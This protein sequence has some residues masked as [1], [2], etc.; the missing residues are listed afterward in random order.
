MLPLTLNMR[1]LNG[2]EK[3]YYLDTGL[4]TNASRPSE[5][6]AGDIMLYGTN[7]LLLFS[8]SFSP[9]YSY[10]PIGHIDDPTELAEALG[11][12]SVQVTFGSVIYT[13]SPTE[14]PTEIPLP[15][16]TTMPTQ[17][18]MPTL[19]PENTPTLTTT[20]TPDGTPM[21]GNTPTPTPTAMP[22]A[23]PTPMPTA[24]PTSEPTNNG[25]PK[26]G[27]V[28]G[29][30]KTTVSDALLVM[31]AALDLMEFNEAQKL[32]GDVDGS[33]TIAVT[34]ALIIMRVALGLIEV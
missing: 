24:T 27:D 8:K 34:D 3:Y 11:S 20:P 19:T 26:D 12:G 23:T 10:T 9:S 21:L 16:D 5:I 1:E 30:G 28:D 22:T 25:N 14:S 31:R 29:D 15:T 13:P 32:H 2:N 4:T 17:T 33:G 18:S 6:N 7:C